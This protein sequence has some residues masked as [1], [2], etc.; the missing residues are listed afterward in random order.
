MISYSPKLERSEFAWICRFLQDKTGI[1]LV[2]GKQ[3]LVSSRLDK[4]LRRL[5]LTTYSEYFRLLQT[6]GHED[7]VRQALDLLTTNETYFFREIKHFDFLR[8]AIIPHH[9][10]SRPLRVWSAA[11]SSGE[12]AYTLAML[13]AEHLRGGSFEIIGTDI[14]SRVVETAQRGLYPL[15]A[16]EKIPPVY[17]KKYCLKGV[18]EYDG[19][20]WV[21]KSLRSRV[22]FRLANLMDPPSDLGTFDVI[23]LR[24]VLIYFDIETKSQVVE[25][26][27]AS[28]RPGGYF[29]VSHSETLHGI[30]VRMTAV[31]PSIYRRD[32]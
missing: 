2:D 7:E 17:L 28:L 4:R 22:S 10:P 31:K 15:S 30:S 18:G 12:E 26:L 23:F 14:S 3:A 11:S 13:L 8:E 32:G 1:L 20:L 24:N 25:A 9:P 5:G 6:P 29:F 19:L 27:E 21:D 16:A